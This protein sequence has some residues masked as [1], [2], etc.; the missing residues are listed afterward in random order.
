MTDTTKIDPTGRALTFAHIDRKVT[1]TQRF[2]SQDVVHTNVRV[3]TLTNISLSEEGEWNRYTKKEEK[4]VVVALGAENPVK[5]TRDRHASAETIDD[6]H[7]W[8]LTSIDD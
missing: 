1:I 3:G 2:V 8:V 5:L 7:S 4:S 6:M